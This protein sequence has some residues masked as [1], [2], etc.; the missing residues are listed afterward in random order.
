MSYN[1][2]VCPV[3][4]SDETEREECVNC[5][6]PVSRFVERPKHG[7]KRRGSG[8]KH[9]DGSDP[10]QGEKLVKR[11]VALPQWMVERLIKLGGGNLSKGVRVMAEQLKEVKED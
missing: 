6:T 9:L 10:G 5:G 3:C 4:G 1:L 2:A 7:G 11:T 8:R